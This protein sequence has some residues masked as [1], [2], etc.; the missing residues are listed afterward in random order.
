MIRHR[1][2][3]RSLW[4]STVVLLALTAV[5]AAVLGWQAWDAAR[6]H[7]AV[8]HASLREQAVFAATN[9][10]R[11][12]R[13]EVLHGLLEEGI[14]VVESAS[15]R[16]GDR[17]LTPD[18]LI[19]A[20]R[21]ER[22]SGLEH[23][24]LA[25]RLRMPDSDFD[26][27]GP[28]GE[29][30]AGWVREQALAF[31]A[32]Q[33]EEHE[34]GFGF[35]PHGGGMLV[36]EISYE[37]GGES[38][39]HGL[40]LDTAAVADAFA[41]AFREEPLLPETLTS[42][43]S[44]EEIFA[45]R[46]VTRDGRVLYASFGDASSNV[47]HQ[48]V[49]PELAGVTIELGVRDSAADLLVSGGVPDSRMP[50]IIVLLLLTCGLLG[51]AVWQLRREAELAELRA[52]FV[53]GV[54]HELM[55]PLTQI[56]M[57][58]ETLQLGRVR[59]DEERARAIEIIVDE[60]TRLAHQV[61]N[62]L[63][64]SRGERDAMRLHPVDTD[65]ASLV[66]E[67]IEGYEPLAESGGVS[68]RLDVEGAPHGVVDPDAIRQVL[69]NLLDNAVKYGPAGQVLKV[70]VGAWADA[71][72][73]RLWVEDEG[74]GISEADRNRIWDPYVRLQRDRDGSSGGSGIGLAVVKR[75]VEAHGG[76]VHAED[77]RRPG[78]GTRFVI[79]LPAAPVQP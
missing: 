11:E 46:V 57:F 8:A 12:A 5:L 25:F 55:T 35:S 70:G 22:W 24:I 49:D 73:V 4:T 40:V 36:H 64:F 19:R 1:P 66:T 68:I 78:T 48:P 71:R 10:A 74:P 28:G 52:D 21:S 38:A 33:P 18:R 14:E 51:T 56:R 20:A 23:T 13:E 53:S 69:L 58:G 31:A 26:W 37:G 6:S 34:L 62:V 54:S 45:A 17:P 50:S 72:R 61:E 42:G 39:V 15:G 79:E 44:N 3:G 29:A 77:S 9:F 32:V 30:L 27:S 7:E 59:N 47:V 41:D 75:A 43:L 63:M 65:L 16:S 2:T 60:S 67:V 76:K